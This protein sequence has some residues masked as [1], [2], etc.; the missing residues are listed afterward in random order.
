VQTNIILSEEKL[1][2]RLS[3]FAAEY[4]PSK[5]KFSAGAERIDNT[6]RSVDDEM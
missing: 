4:N 3:Y 1:G 5:G 2:I 6:T